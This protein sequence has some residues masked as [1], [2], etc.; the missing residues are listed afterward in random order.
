[1]EQLGDALALHRI[2]SRRLP[3]RCSNGSDL[4]QEWQSS[5]ANSLLTKCERGPATKRQ[6]LCNSYSMMR[7]VLHRC[8]RSS[9]TA[10]SLGRMVC[11]RGLY[12]RNARRAAGLVLD[13]GQRVANRNGRACYP[14]IRYPDVGDASGIAQSVLPDA[15]P[16]CRPLV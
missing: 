1:M 8:Q 14:Q 3:H 10:R 16:A 13:C 5:P 15:Q 11:R 2:S 12:S 9:I 6:V 7:R 4:S